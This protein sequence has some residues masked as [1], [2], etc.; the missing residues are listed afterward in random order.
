MTGVLTLPPRDAI[1]GTAGTSGGIRNWALFGEGGG[2]YK[3]R[4]Q[5][6]PGDA[7]FH[8]PSLPASVGPGRQGADDCPK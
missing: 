3:G 2:A 7:L 6:Q 8:S 4:A 5:E 1:Q